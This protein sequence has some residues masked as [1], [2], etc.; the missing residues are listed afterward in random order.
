MN[1]STFSNYKI[2]MSWVDIFVTLY[3]LFFEMSSRQIFQASLDLIGSSDPLALA[4][5]VAGTIG[6][7]HHAWLFCTFCILYF[8]KRSFT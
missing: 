6:I 7:C 8:K 2:K 3:V 1:K 4:S 5:K